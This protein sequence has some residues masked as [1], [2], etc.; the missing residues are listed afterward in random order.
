L[1]YYILLT[2]VFTSQPVVVADTCNEAFEPSDD[3]VNVTGDVEPISVVV[4]SVK[5][6]DEPLKIDITCPAL[7][8]V[9]FDTV[10]SNQAPVYPLTGME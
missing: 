1:P 4:V 10:Y 2:I 7:A 8:P 5:L 9:V 6:T 3:I